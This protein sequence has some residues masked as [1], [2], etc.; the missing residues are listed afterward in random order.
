MAWIRGEWMGV[1]YLTPIFDMGFKQCWADFK[2]WLCSEAK[3]HWN[4]KWGSHALYSPDLQVIRRQRST[5]LYKNVGF[6]RKRNAG[7]PSLSNGQG[8][9]VWRLT[10]TEF[11]RRASKK[12]YLSVDLLTSHVTWR[13]DNTFAALCVLISANLLRTGHLITRYFSP[14]TWVSR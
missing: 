1:A 5:W 6:P 2:A 9:L 12:F 14:N 4:E 10:S 13:R 11:L 3:C 7:D 8:Y